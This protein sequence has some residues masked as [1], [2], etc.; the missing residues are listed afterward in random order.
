MAAVLAIL[1]GGLLLLSGIAGAGTWS[2]LRDALEKHVEMDGNLEMVF[3]V[4][5]LLGSFGGLTVM[6]GGW[7]LWR[8]MKRTGRVLVTIGVGIGL[9]GLVLALLI[10]TLKGDLEGFLS[11]S[12]GLV[13]IVLSIAARMMAK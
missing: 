7:F 3:F 9:I 12:A 10:A 11:P 8:G 13:G 5:I 4:L 1:A 2:S 6:A